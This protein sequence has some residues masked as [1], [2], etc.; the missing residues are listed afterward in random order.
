MLAPC[1]DLDQRPLARTAA[2]DRL[3]RAAVAEAVSLVERERVAAAVLLTGSLARGA[4]CGVLIGGEARLLSDVDLG[5]VPRPDAPPDV[6]ERL[7][8]LA[9]EAT[10][11]AAALGLV[12]HV[13]F[14]LLPARVLARPRDRL[15]LHDLART[16]VTV[17]GDDGHLETLRQQLRGRRVDVEEGRILILNRI[18]GQ[19]Y[20]LG[21][22]ASPDPL[23]RL[24]ARYQ[25]AK[26]YADSRLAL[27]IVD[28]TYPGDASYHPVLDRQATAARRW[29][30]FRENPPADPGPPAR[31]LLEWKAAVRDQLEVARAA[32]ALRPRRGVP[33]VFHALAWSRIPDVSPAWSERLGFKGSPL[34]AAHAR[35][36][37]LAGALLE[38]C[39]D[40]SAWARSAR[41]AVG[42]WRLAVNGTDDTPA[43]YEARVRDLL[44]RES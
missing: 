20:M 14:G 25:F 28:R 10:R 15:V 42:F 40:A 32:G 1:V 38:E 29:D 39:A 17:A 44:R 21:H 33:N 3:A 5:V 16:G 24:V 22:L 35:C 6:R 8:R 26:A 31:L 11:R 19:V 18:A 9:A 13:E 12:S 27:A 4:A 37:S 7:A 2:V 41:E 43:D 30:A 23:D 34:Q 36:V